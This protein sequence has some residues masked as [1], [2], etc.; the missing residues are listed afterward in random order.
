[1]TAGCKFMSYLFCEY[2]VVCLSNTIIFWIGER[3]DDVKYWQEDDAELDFGIP[4]SDEERTDHDLPATADA[5]KYAIIQSVVSSLQMCVLDPSFPFLKSC[6][7][8]HYVYL[9][10]SDCPGSVFTK[11]FLACPFISW[12]SS[13]ES[14]VFRQMQGTVGYS[15]NYVRSLFVELTTV[16]IALK[17]AWKNEVPV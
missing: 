8:A 4:S 17:S 9:Y 10:S 14:S 12:I 6:A 1:M 16:S 2:Y 11:N 13:P 3:K 15:C 5:E 7:M